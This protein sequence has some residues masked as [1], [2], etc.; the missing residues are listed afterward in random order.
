M[1]SDRK[2]PIVIEELDFRKKK[3]PLEAALAV[4]G[5]SGESQSRVSP[6]ERHGIAVIIPFVVRQDSASESLLAPSE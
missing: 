6:T 4:H 3:A 1:A 5:R 2:K